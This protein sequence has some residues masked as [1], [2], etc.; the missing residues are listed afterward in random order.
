MTVRVVVDGGTIS[1]VAVVSNQETENIA[2][3]A[4]EKVPA[5]IVEQN[6]PDVDGVTG[7]TLTSGRIMEAVKK[8][9]DQA[10]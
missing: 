1:E 7:A 9:L 10:K 3:P 5:S 6:S 2:A 4:I 8:C